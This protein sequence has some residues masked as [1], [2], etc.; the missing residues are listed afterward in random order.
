[1]FGSRVGQ[2]VVTNGALWGSAIVFALA[3]ALLIP[4]TQAG[5]VPAA[6]G[7]GSLR[8]AGLGTYVAPERAVH[9]LVAGDDLVPPQVLAS[10]TSG[11]GP[12]MAVYDPGNGFV[13]AVNSISNS[14]SV[15][16]GTS[17][18]ATVPVS[19]ATITVGD[20][21]FLVYDSANG[22]VYVLDR[23]SFET[24]GGDVSVIDGT[25]LLTIVPIGLSPF[26]AAYD[27][28]NGYVYVTE[29]GADQVAVLDG[30]TVIA[31]LPAG[32][33][34]GAIV[35]NPSNGYVYAANRGS[36]NLSVFDGTSPVAAVRVGSDPDA[37]AYDGALSAVYVA[38][39][40]SGNVT[41]VVGTSAIGSADTGTNPSFAVVD[42]SN[43]YAYVA[44]RNSSDVSVLNGTVPVG[45]VP[46]GAGP[47][48]DAFG[49]ATGLVYVADFAGSE[50]TVID[51][52]QVLGNVPVGSGPTSAAWDVGNDYLYVTNVNSHN[53]SVV[54][55]AYPLYF[56]ETGLPSSTPWSVTVGSKL[57]AG[58]TGSL[59][60]GELPGAY[61]YAIASPSGYRVV[62]ATPV[63]PVTVSEAPSAVLVTFG[64]VSSATYDLSF[65]ETGLSSMCGHST[66]W[67]VTVANVTLSSTSTTI[68]F[69][70]PNGTYNYSVAGP[71]GYVV[72]SESPASPVTISGAPLTVDV[73]FGKGTSAPSTFTITFRE[74]GLR[75]GTTWCVNL[76]TTTV[77]SSSDE[78]QFNGLSSGTYGFSV[79]PVNGYT[80]QP[81]SG[82]VTIY[83]HNAYVRIQFS[84]QGG[85]HCGGWQPGGA[86]AAA[87]PIRP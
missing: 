39:N 85:H 26:A 37:L 60:I 1:M 24:T 78:I 7:G 87:P 74:S 3:I 70:E 30:T 34:P 49:A 71:S 43:G 84:S 79:V 54:A 52:T 9:P 40:D 73:T 20:P 16:S 5:A 77:C 29:G 69:A 55:I 81:S 66:E 58:S 25:S 8:P 22:Y 21:T 80:A 50:V 56:N 57:V 62:S 36:A 13:Y 44:N 63:S 86:N 68:V 12:A 11:S 64:P 33:A 41:L 14:V 17:L 4:L 28:G 75:W 6:G 48:W 35:Y 38:N 53:V 19:N 59:E 2:N 23:Y 32:D 82:T 83:Y 46:T 51:G 67:S 10:V 31:Q 27:A 76:G 72:T 47:A 61:A 15:L 45:T 18:L 42:P 65:V